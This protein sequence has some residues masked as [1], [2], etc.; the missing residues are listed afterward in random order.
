MNALI[1]VTDIIEKSILLTLIGLSI[2]SVSIILDRRKIFKLEMAFPFLDLRSSIDAKSWD[3]ALN[4]L[5]QHQGA[6]SRTLKNTFKISSADLIDR[7]V[8]SVYRQEKILLEKGFSVLATL[9]ANAPFIG[10]LGTVLGIIRAFAYLGSQAGSASV[11]SGVSQA[12]Y[13]TAI[14]LAV[15]IPAVIFYNV[16][17]KK[18]KDL[19]SQIE[20]LKDLI[21]ARRFDTQKRD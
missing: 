16:F 7:E 2:W 14:G 12:L 3:Q 9:G 10:L 15:A 18:L 1:I 20:S 4:I 13:A 5:S 8:S 11:M 19:Q 17:T 21:I 6:V